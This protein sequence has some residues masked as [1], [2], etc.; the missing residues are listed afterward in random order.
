[1]QLIRL[2]SNKT[3]FHTVDFKPGVNLI[4]GSA[5]TKN[6]NDTKKTYNGVG[7]SLLIKII[8]FC[9][10]CEAVTEFSAKLIDWDFTLEFEVGGKKYISTRSTSKQQRITLNGEEMSIDAFRD[11]FVDKIFGITEP[12]HYLTWRSLISR[13]LRPRKESYVHFN[14]TSAKET[15]YSK[16]INTSYLLG[17][18]IG[19]IQRKKE[20]KVELD[21]IDTMK[22]SLENDEIFQKYFTQDKDVDIEVVDLEDKVKTLKVFLES[23]Q[24]SD[25]YYD[26]QQE[27]DKLKYDGQQIKNRITLLQNSIIQIDKTIEIKSDVTPETIVKLYSEAKQHLQKAVIKTLEEVNDFHTTLTRERKE[28]LLSEKK[29]LFSEVETLEKKRKDAGDKLNEHLKF[30]GKHKALDE[31]VAVNTKL[32]DL[33]ISLEKL[34]SYKG[35]LQEYQNKTDEIGIIFSEENIKTNNYLTEA[36]S[37]TEKNINT[38]RLLS[39]RFYDDK[40]GGIEVKQN[41]GINQVRFDI[42]VHIDDDTSDGVNEVKIF[43]FDMTLLLTRHT[44]SVRFILHDSRL[45]SNIDPRQRATLFRLCD[46]YSTKGKFQYIATVN[47]DQI[48]S[49]REHYSKDEYKKIIGDNRI[50]DL[51][52]ESEES[53]LLGVH[54]NIDYE[55]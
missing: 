35:L 55:K 7:K 22:M 26:I 2:Y 4:V 53:R 14:S 54:L 28:R 30:L 29:Q 32:S 1:M 17:L 45:Y 27:A 38:F 52:D 9:L 15:P 25:S 49:V 44:H 20:L 42:N 18:D 8:D 13:F 48:E 11:F 36:H 5:T 23:F 41:K 33:N 21:R 43:C 39:K 16:L 24:V 40:A 31:F 37:L 3:S 10:A 47:E 34:K 50:L 51:T 6:K 46:E 12:V 19:L